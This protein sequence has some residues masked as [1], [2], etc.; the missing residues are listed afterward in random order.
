MVDLQELMFFKALTHKVDSEETLGDMKKEIFDPTSE[1]EN[2]GGI[3]AFI[4]SILGTAF[5]INLTENVTTATYTADKTYTQIQAAFDA[6][7]VIMANV[8]NTSLFPLL[9]AEISDGSA[10]YTFGYTRVMADGSIV[11]TRAINY[12]HTPSSDLWSDADLELEPLLLTGGM[13][14]GDLNMGSNSISNIHSLHVE[15]EEAPIFIGSEIEAVGT[16]GVRIAGMSEGDAAVLSPSS[17]TTYKPIRVG[18]PTMDE[19]AVTKKLLEESLTD[20]LTKITAKTGQLKVYCANGDKQDQCI[21]SNSGTAN[22]IARYD[23][24][25]RLLSSAT[26]SSDTHLANK[27]YVDEAIAAFNF[28]KSDFFVGGDLSVTGRA[29]VLGE[30]IN[31]VDVVNKGYLKNIFN[32]DSTTKTLNITI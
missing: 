26:P 22:A 12:L 28:A 9:D 4:K 32:Y 17:Q 24:S 31:D 18:T 1:V 2:A 7:K 5:V 8:N 23:N 15:G 6:N 3:P 30:P 25:G 11:F 16:S 27:K 14:A 29:Y 20:K 13:M 10:G 21:V 19:H